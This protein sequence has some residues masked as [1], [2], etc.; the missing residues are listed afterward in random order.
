MIKSKLFSVFAISLL[1]VVSSFTTCMLQYRGVNE[2]KTQIK[3]KKKIDNFFSA[4]NLAERSFFG[5]DSCDDNVPGDLDKNLKQVFVTYFD[6]F[7]SVSQDK[8]INYTCKIVLLKRALFRLTEFIKELYKNSLIMYSEKSFFEHF[9][10][11]KMTQYCFNNYWDAFFAILANPSFDK[12]SES[13][14]E[15]L[16]GITRELQKVYHWFLSGKNSKNKDKLT[17]IIKEKRRKIGY[18]LFQFYYLA[19]SF[20]EN[21]LLAKY[22]FSGDVTK[23]RKFNFDSLN[24]EKRSYSSYI[25]L[26]PNIKMK[27]LLIQKFFSKKEERERLKKRALKKLKRL[28]KLKI[29][30]LLINLELPNKDDL[31]DD[32]KKGF[33]ELFYLYAISKIEIYKKRKK[34]GSVFI[35]K[36]PC[37]QQV[38]GM[39]KSFSLVHSKIF[40]QNNDLLNI[41]KKLHRANVLVDKANLET[42]TGS[43]LKLFS[44][45]VEGEL[46]KQKYKDSYFRKRFKLRDQNAYI[47]FIE[48]KSRGKKRK[49]ICKYKDQ[50]KQC[51]KKKESPSQVFTTFV[52]SNKGGHLISMR[53]EKTEGND[54]VVF[55]T[56]SEHLCKDYYN[57]WLFVGLS[58]VFGC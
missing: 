37:L 48:V 12:S 9:L 4:V 32:L 40:A 52:E 35:V 23:L 20:E 13:K 33:S 26:A 46:V 27:S 51:L 7:E 56:D 45:V 47:N 16:L 14:V 2:E 49:V 42:I 10:L 25:E 21:F 39:C 44:A 6:L 30:N 22:I 53:V 57:N 1:C 29:K 38:G 17:T 8:E 36:L 28:K 11:H 50:I 3:S 43:F 18:R 15:A 55:Y 31:K 24:N 34:E 58:R 54:L 5:D 19:K 41:I